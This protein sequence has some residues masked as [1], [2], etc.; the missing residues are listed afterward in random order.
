M[1]RKHSDREC[2]D[3]A[4]M[5][6]ENTPNCLFLQVLFEGQL[7]EPLSSLM[8]REDGDPQPPFPAVITGSMDAEEGEMFILTSHTEWFYYMWGAFDHS[9]HA[10]SNPTDVMA[11][12]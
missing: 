4:Q 5:T 9:E 12:H 6:G 10:D 2:L 7:V 11:A 1:Q 3:V 8:T